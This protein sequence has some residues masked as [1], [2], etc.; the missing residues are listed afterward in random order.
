M[1]LVGL[2]SE[3]ASEAEIAAVCKEVKIRQ[4]VVG[5][6][7]EYSQNKKKVE[8]AVDALGCWKLVQFEVVVNVQ[9]R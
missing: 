9:Y 4:P 6:R 3:T 5:A 8:I 2:G 1:E 7:G